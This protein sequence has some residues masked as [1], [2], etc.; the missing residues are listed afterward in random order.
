MMCYV[1]ILKVIIIVW[2]VIR[3]FFSALVKWCIA[4]Q[5]LF[6]TQYIRVC[7][8]LLLYFHIIILVM[9]F[10]GIGVGFAVLEELVLEWEIPAR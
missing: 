8:P 4:T 2:V 9:I 1:F 7:L 5:K 10:W 3:I 6:F